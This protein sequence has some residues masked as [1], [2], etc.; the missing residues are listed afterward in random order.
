MKLRNMAFPLLALS[1]SLAN[2]CS[3]KNIPQEQAPQ[4]EK[5]FDVQV[6]TPQFQNIPKEYSVDGIFETS[7]TVKITAQTP[8]QI[9]KILVKEGDQ[10]EQNADLITFSA[11]TL[12][13]T[14]ELN[15]T[16]I[17]EIE[18]RVKSIDALLVELG[19]DRPTTAEDISFLDEKTFDEGSQETAASSTNTLATLKKPETL[20]ALKTALEASLQRLQ[21]TNELLEKQ[22]QELTLKTQFAG[23]VLKTHVSEANTVS[24]GQLLFEIV[25]NNPI[26]VVFSLPKDVASFV[27]QQSEVRFSLHD[28]KNIRGEGKVYFISPNL[29]DDNQTL[30]VKALFP[31]PQYLIKSGQKAVVY[32]TTS[33]M[34]RA[35]ILPQTAIVSVAGKDFIFLLHGN[36]AKMQE[37]SVGRK[38]DATH[39]EVTT[40]IHSDQKII[41]SVPEGLQDNS[42]VKIVE[43][44]AN[45]M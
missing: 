14:L 36:R 19:K 32:V 28:A 18:T 1:F 29:S 38:K 11:T 6:I 3:R 24:A 10:I 31:N 26:S 40:T 17:K 25:K 33:H 34:E 42:F 7:E 39:V 43:N 5:V 30:T 41:E 12:T 44:S 2:P 23:V 37:V 20:K 27:T 13:E 21:K 45:T 16:Q 35:L 15:Q 4:G 9:E 8:A 22:K